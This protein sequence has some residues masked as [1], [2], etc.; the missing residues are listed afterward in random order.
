MLSGASRFPSEPKNNLKAHGGRSISLAPAS[1]LAGVLLAA[2]LLGTALGIQLYLPAAVLVAGLAAT[3]GYAWYLFLAVRK[4]QS[5]IPLW[6]LLLS[7]LLLIPL[8]QAVVG[9]KLNF[10]AELILFAASPI[11][12]VAAWKT[13][14]WTTR[15][16]VFVAAFLAYLVWQVLV[17]IFGRSGLL[18]AA[19]QFVTNLKPFALLLLGFSLAWHSSTER[20]FWFVVRWAWVYIGLLVV[21]QVVSPATYLSNFGG[22]LLVDQTPNPLL[23]FFTRMQGPFEHSSVLA[24]FSIQFVL[25]SA[26][27]AWVLREWRYAIFAV[28]YLILAVLS[29]QRQEIF[30]FLIALL[31]LW[32]SVRYRAGLLQILSLSL[33]GSIFALIVL[34]PILGE[35]FQNELALWRTSGSFGAEGVRSALYDAAFRIAS[36]NAPLGSGLGTFGGPGAV[37]FDQSLYVEAGLGRFWW[38]QRGLFLQDSIWA[39]YIAEQGWIGAVWLAGLFAAVLAS[40]AAT[41]RIAVSPDERMYA[42]IAVAVLVYALLVSPTAFVITDPVTGLLSFVIVGMAYR[43]VRSVRQ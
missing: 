28:P 41:Y 18:P 10:T 13:L 31:I 5:D 16:R 25:L 43:R 21:L 40:A 30:V 3:A 20:A 42:L 1:L 22:N 33:A 27:R 11:A 29:G 9:V 6:G 19:Y 14:R 39:C 35:N 32:V 26:C 17:S 37:R 36:D 23:P 15:E 7:G 2:L 4:A 8:S 12:I 38:F 24:T 34:W